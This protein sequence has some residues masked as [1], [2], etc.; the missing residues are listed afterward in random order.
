LFWRAT[1]PAHGATRFDVAQSVDKRATPCSGAKVSNDLGIVR[2]IFRQLR[3]A[4]KMFLYAGP[5]VILVECAS[6]WISSP[7]KH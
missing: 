5:N 6:K 7:Q 4:L 2:F 1:L 3:E